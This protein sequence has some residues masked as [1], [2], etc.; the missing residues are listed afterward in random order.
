MQLHFFPRL[1]NQICTLVVFFPLIISEIERKITLPIPTDDHP[2]R[3][4]LSLLLSCFFLGLNCVKR[5]QLQRK[6]GMSLS[7][8]W[9]DYI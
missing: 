5:D 4:L 7:L 6:M 8:L 1:P 2:Y 9:L 3:F